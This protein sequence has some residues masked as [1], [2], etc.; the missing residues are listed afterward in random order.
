MRDTFSNPGP[1]DAN[2]PRSFNHQ[3]HILI[4]LNSAR[5]NVSIPF[6]TPPVFTNLSNH[7]GRGQEERGIRERA[8]QRENVE[9]IAR[10]KVQQRFRNSQSTASCSNTL[11]WSNFPPTTTHYSPLPTTH[12]PL[13]TVVV[14]LKALPNIKT[15]I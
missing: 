14:Y 6:L 5:L 8:S 12:P 15:C 1:L 2:A 4:T 10:Y 13:C 7:A 9:E 11:A 3:F